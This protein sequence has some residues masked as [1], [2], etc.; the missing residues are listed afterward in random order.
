MFS[1]ESARG[2]FKPN[3]QVQEYK[4]TFIK[5]YD[6]IYIENKKEGKYVCLQKKI[7]LRASRMESQ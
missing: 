3:P 6:I 7:Y 4:L 5:K 1:H 2:K